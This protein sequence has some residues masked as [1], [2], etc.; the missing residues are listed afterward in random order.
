MIHQLSLLV[1]KGFFIETLKQGTCDSWMNKTQ[2]ALDLFVSKPRWSLCRPLLKSRPGRCWCS[3]K[4][5]WGG[6]WKGNFAEQIEI[7]ISRRRL[8]RES[9]EHKH[10][11]IKP[12]ASLGEL[13]P[14]ISNPSGG[15]L[16]DLRA[17]CPPALL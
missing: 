12:F 13:L 17:P 14:S 8:L 9:V 3:Q 6:Q 10:L 16:Q 15:R 11:S 1:V 7:I 2:I 5:F 4:G